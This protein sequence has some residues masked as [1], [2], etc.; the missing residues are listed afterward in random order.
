MASPSD[1]RP[2]AARVEAVIEASRLPEHYLKDKSERGE[3]RIENLEELAR[4]AGE[5]VLDPESQLDPLTAFLSQAALEAG[6]G[7]AEDG[8]D[9]VE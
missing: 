8:A 1:N 6:E 4:A 5:L 7:Q 9:G 2:L 3:D